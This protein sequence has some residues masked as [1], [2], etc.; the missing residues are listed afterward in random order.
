MTHKQKEERA[1]AREEENSENSA[2]PR[3]YE[4]GFHIDPELSQKEVKRIFQEMKTIAENAGALIATSE[5][6]KIQLAY[7][8]SHMEHTGR[9]DFSAA[10]FVWIAYE[11]TSAAHEKVIAAAHA[12]KNIFRFIDIS[13]T[14][15]AALHAAEQYE[16]RAR[17]SEKSTTKDDA[18]SEEQLN[19]ALE[20]ATV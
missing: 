15:E 6:E 5:P 13:T 2:E 9:H 18:V 14:K 3:V 7:T 4:L 17:V 1:E 19:A 20:E 12:E 16:M 11:A 10:F 8:I